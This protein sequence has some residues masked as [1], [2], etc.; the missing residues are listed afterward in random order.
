M[1]ALRWTP[2]ASVRRLSSSRRRHPRI[3]HAATLGV[4]GGA[5]TFKRLGSNDFRILG[6]FEAWSNQRDASKAIRAA[7]SVRAT[8][9]ITWEPWAPPPIGTK[10]QGAAQPRFSNRSIAAGTTRSLHPPVRQIARA[11][12]RTVYLRLAHEFPGQWYPWSIDP[13]SYRR[14]WRRIHLIFRRS[15]ASNVRFIWSPQLYA[16]QLAV[17]ARPYWPGSQYVDFVSTSFVHFGPSH[18]PH[19]P[20][21]AG[22]AQL[23]E[24]GKPAIISEANVEYS[25]RHEVMRE[26][27]GVRQIESLDSRHRLVAIDIPRSARLGTDADGVASARRRRSLGDSQVDALSSPAARRSEIACIP[28]RP[29]SG[30]PGNRSTSCSGR[31]DRGS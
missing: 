8:P 18:G 22:L 6:S 27:G 4:D 23:K 24:F 20:M 5:S 7:R 19:G 3:S 29:T 14:A 30:R 13:E 31:T 28:G 15:G 12:R 21:I 26:L 9:L 2:A 10:D 16:N 1:K 25:N 17:R 11:H